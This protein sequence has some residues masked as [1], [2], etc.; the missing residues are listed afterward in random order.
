MNNR[1]KF[2]FSFL[3]Y[4]YSTQ[5]NSSK[6]HKKY[7]GEVVNV[8]VAFAVIVFIFRWATSSLS[9]P[10]RSDRNTLTFCAEG[11]DTT[12]R[13]AADT[14]G[15]RPKPV[16]QDMVRIR[17]PKPGNMLTRSTT[18]KH[19]IEYVPWYSCVSTTYIISVDLLRCLP[20]L[21]LLVATMS[22]TTFCELAVL[23]SRRIRS[24]RGGF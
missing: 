6:T 17:P 11:N 9:T 8:L 2:S 10:F 20:H 18:D 1:K 5:S 7:M 22:A 21:D 14:L 23:N 15:F 13:S 4:F 19:Y 12:E 24:W 16:T 3:Y